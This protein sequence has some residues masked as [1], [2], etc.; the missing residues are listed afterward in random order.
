MGSGVQTLECFLLVVA[1]LIKSSGKSQ[2]VFWYCSNRWIRNLE[3]FIFWLWES[4]TSVA[5]NFC[6]YRRNLERVEKSVA[7]AS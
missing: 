4:D 2:A 5:G 3:M 1:H 6:S 7:E